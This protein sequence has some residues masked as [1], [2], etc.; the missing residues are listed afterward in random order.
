MQTIGLD[1]EYDTI[2]SGLH[3]TIKL[4]TEFKQFLTKLDEP[5]PFAGELKPVL[6]IYPQLQGIFNENRNLSLATIIRYDNILR[7]HLRN[8]MALIL[9]FIYQ[10]DVY[11][12]VS[13]VARTKGFCYAQALPKEAYTIRIKDCRHPGIEKAVANPVNM[14]RNSNVVFLTGANM[15]GKSTFMKSFAIAV[16]LG[17]MGFPVAATAME[18]SVRDGIYT[19][20]NV[21]DNLQLGYS[22]FYAE[23][24]RVKTVAEDVSAGKNL[25]V[26]F[27]ELFKG[28]NVKDAYDAT[29][30]VTKAFSEY[31]NCFFIISTHIIEVADALQT[32][33]NNLQFVFFPT[34]M[35]GSIPRYTYQLQAGVTSDRHG[36]MIIQNEGIIGI[37]SQTAS[38]KSSI[39]KMQ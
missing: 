17:H 31:R 11:I 19:S 25:V 28:T 22:H 16:Y 33:C 26:I 23:V 5:G 8:E 30:A 35:E 15:A 9:R 39:P 10:L 37:I 34:V 6:D 14:Q 2:V 24:R 36:M 7:L 27:D 18:F 12:A 1:K 3:T 21:P 32:A 4:L 29:L 20:I 38:K 13:A